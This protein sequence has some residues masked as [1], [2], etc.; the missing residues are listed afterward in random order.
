MRSQA[1]LTQNTIM[2]LLPCGDCVAA[3]TADPAF[4][5]TVS[6]GAKRVWQEGVV[7]DMR[8]KLRDA[9][10]L[11]ADGKRV[12]LGLG[13]GGKEPVRFDLVSFGLND[14]AQLAPD[15]AASKFAGLGVTDWED[16]F[17]PK[18]NG[19]PIAL[20]SNERSQSCY[21]AGRVAFLLGTDWRLRAYRADGGEL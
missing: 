15:L 5:L 19:N 21:R 14:A 17:A 7:V 11:S 2:Q 4:G 18:L 13:F 1:P 8:N 12:R 20:E 3:G 16:Q 10:T 9:F 6:D